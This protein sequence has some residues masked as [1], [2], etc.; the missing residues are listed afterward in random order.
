MSSYATCSDT[1][2]RLEFDFDEHGRRL[3]VGG[4]DRCVRVYDVPS[5]KLLKKLEGLEDVAN[6]ISYTSSAALNSGLLA[7][8][9]G[10]RRFPEDTGVEQEDCGSVVTNVPGSVELYKV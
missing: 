3:F 1:N 6:G 4:H 8:A 9:V 10:A 5:G 2:Q 7:V